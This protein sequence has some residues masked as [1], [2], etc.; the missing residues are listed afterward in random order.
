MGGSRGA[1]ERDVLDVVATSVQG[2]ELNMNANIPSYPLFERGVRRRSGVT[3][4]M[5]NFDIRGIP[6]WEGSVMKL[7]TVVA[8]LPSLKT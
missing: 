3:K 7:L 5:K 8:K 4:E 2:A 1:R 6:L